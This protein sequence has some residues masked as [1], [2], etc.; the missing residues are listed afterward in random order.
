MSTGTTEEAGNKQLI[1]MDIEEIARIDAATKAKNVI[2]NKGYDDI[3]ISESKSIS[4]SR[5]EISQKKDNAEMQ[6]EEKLQQQ[7]QRKIDTLMEELPLKVKNKRSLDQLVE[8]KPK[9]IRA[10]EH[11]M[12][13]QRKIN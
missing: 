1:N 13:P 9:K 10:P 11:E 4:G 7:H 8:R 2:K 5:K 6:M 3:L 12:T